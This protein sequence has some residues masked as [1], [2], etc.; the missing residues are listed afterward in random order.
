MYF[1]SARL[2]AITLFVVFYLVSAMG[3]AAYNGN[4]EF[5]FYGVVVCCLMAIVA[6]MDWRV[7]FSPLVL[8]GLAIWGLVHLAGGLM[9]IPAAL[10]E[11]GGDP[12]LYSLRLHPDLPKFDQLVHVYGFGISAL[13]TY[14]ALC[15]RFKT[16]LPLDSAV[17]F[18]VF[19]VAIG[20]GTVN[21]IIEFIAVLV[22]PHTNVGGYINTGWDMVSNAVGAVLAIAYLKYLKK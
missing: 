17:I 11:P 15:V 13:A 2:R 22:M 20:L 3:L 8:W 12:V 16:R 9:P 19:L 18:I 1:L 21:E 6:Y 10:T 4:G 5:I 14:E 7:K